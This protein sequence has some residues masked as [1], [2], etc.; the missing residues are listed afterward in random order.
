MHV[1]LAIS[2]FLYTLLVAVA[3]LG[4]YRL[5]QKGSSQKTGHK[6]LPITVLIPFRNEESNLKHRFN[7]LINLGYG[8][9]LEVLWIDDHSEDHSRALIAGL[10]QNRE[11]H[12]LICLQSKF[13]KKAALEAG[14]A[15]ATTKHIVTIDADSSV[16]QNWLALISATFSA[17]EA[18]MLILPVSIPTEAGI[19][20]FFQSAENCAIQGLSFGCAALSMPISCN[21]ANLAFKKSAFESVGGYGSHRDVASGDDVLLMQ[22]FVNNDLHVRPL[23]NA[24]ALVNTAPVNGWNSIWQQRLRWAGKNGRMTRFAPIGVGLILWVHSLFLIVAPL[25][26]VSMGIYGVA[27]M[28]K[29]AMDVLL[30]KTAATRYKLSLNPLKLAILSIGYTF[31]LPVVA[32]VSLLWRPKWKGRRT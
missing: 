17:G 30:I 11:H 12:R 4:L 29:I 18:D 9:E 8:G 22:T 25:F 31:Y 15:Q 21:G 13:G 7:E 32:F 14:I 1:V 27:W 26:K 16:K 10:I 2:T 20:A 23:W 6:L 3:L 24:G 5:S 28:L 19:H